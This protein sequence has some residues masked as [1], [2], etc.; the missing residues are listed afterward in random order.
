[1][2]RAA[3]KGMR[4]EWYLDQCAQPLPKTHLIPKRENLAP[5]PANKGNSMINRFQMLNMDENDTEEGSEDGELLSE[6]SSL[7]VNH[8][9]P[10]NTRTVAA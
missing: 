8:R 3:Y 10:W 9:S 2:S 6:F 4:I 5:P 1:M 7:N